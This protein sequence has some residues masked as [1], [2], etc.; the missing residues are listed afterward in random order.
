[1]IDQKHSEK[2]QGE[3]PQGGRF[4]G[5]DHLHLWVGNAKQ[6]AGW[7]TTHFGF[8]YY[9]Y[10][11]LE[12]G[13]RDVCTHVIRNHKGVTLAFSSPYGNQNQ[14][15]IEMN[16]H[17]SLHGDGVRD[18]AF[19]V[20]NCISIYNKAV[21]RGAKPVF[22][23][24]TLEDQ[25]GKVI[26]ASVHTY[27]DTIHTFVQRNEYK[28]HFMPG[29]VPHYLKCT[30]NDVLKPI[31][32]NFI[33]HVVGNQ[34]DNKMVDAASWYEKHLDF[35]R[36]W[37]VDDSMIHT[38]YSSLRSIVVTDFDQIVK[39]PINE[40]ANG[41]K[42]SQIQEYVDYYAGSGVQHVALNTN[43]IIDTVEGLRSRGVEFL[44]I[45]QTYY[46]NLRKN[47]SNQN[48]I[49][50]KEDL[51]KIQKNNI[52]VDYDEKGYLL[53]I[54]TKPVED[55]PTLFYEIIQRNNHQG[56]GAG[57]FKSLFLSIEQEQEKRG[58]LTEIQDNYKLI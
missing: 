27:G 51:D 45:P 6:A 24:K 20:E 50:V 22:E 17:Q 43:D 13:S 54:F 57:N 19:T 34:P 48:S 15:Q 16:Q 3:R 38:E 4:L 36:F 53:Q 1:M 11:G 35:H 23:P 33:D 41:K 26:V 8:Q 39:M 44:S 37:S 21:T 56:F 14:E 49:Q 32:Y 5:F 58:N 47:L 2:P 9:A 12:T 40:P 31:D 10:K 46:D 25:Y 7:Y 30:I 29:F 28:G 52:L 55:R 42:K 18:V